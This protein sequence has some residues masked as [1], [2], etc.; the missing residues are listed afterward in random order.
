VLGGT[1]GSLRLQIAARG[2]ASMMVRL[3]DIEGSEAPPRRHPVDLIVVAPPRGELL[4]ISPSRLAEISLMATLDRMPR[5]VAMGGAA[6]HASLGRLAVERASF[7][8]LDVA[9][10]LGE[11]PGQ[12]REVLLGS[13]RRWIS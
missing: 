11:R 1:A 5:L 3:V 12:L 13:I 4:A 9:A 2:G 10:A 6:L 7:E 8:L